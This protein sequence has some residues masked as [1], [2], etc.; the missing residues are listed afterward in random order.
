MFDI[1]QGISRVMCNILVS[2]FYQEQVY[3]HLYTTYMCMVRPYS[4]KI[5]ASS[6]QCI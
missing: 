6:E 2:T 1:N 5:M 3:P 4:L